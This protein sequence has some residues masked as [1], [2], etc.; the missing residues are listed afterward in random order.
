[1]DNVSIQIHF[2]NKYEKTLLFKISNFITTT[3]KLKIN[4]NDFKVHIHKWL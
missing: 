3:K 2:N 4:R 1:M